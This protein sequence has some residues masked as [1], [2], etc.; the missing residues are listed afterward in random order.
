MTY[1]NAEQ[2]LEQRAQ[3]RPSINEE[4]IEFTGKPLDFIWTDKV[5]FKGYRLWHEFKIIGE[6]LIMYAAL[7][8]AGAIVVNEVEETHA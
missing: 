3:L 1:E 2:I 4:M 7:G 6:N 8:P 5:F